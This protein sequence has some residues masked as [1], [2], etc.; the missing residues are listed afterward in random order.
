MGTNKNNE[1]RLVKKNYLKIQTLQQ[2][3]LNNNDSA[4][5]Q[6]E[7]TPMAAPEQIATSNIVVEIVKKSKKTEKEYFRALC[8][9][10]REAFD[11]HEDSGMIIKTFMKSNVNK[12]IVARKK[13]SRAIVGYAAIL[14]EDASKEYVAKQRKIQ[15]KHNIQVPKGCYLMRIGVRARCQGQG[16]GRKLMA[17]LFETFPAHLKLDVSSDN[18]KAIGFYHRIG[19]EI[20][21]TY[22]TE[23]EQVEFVKFATPEDFVYTALPPRTQPQITHDITNNNEIAV[24]D[25]VENRNVEECRGRDLILNNRA[26]SADQAATLL[27]IKQESSLTAGASSEQT[28]SSPKK[29]AVSKATSAANSDEET[30]TS[31]KSAKQEESA[32][33]A[34]PADFF[35]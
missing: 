35:L 11:K 23:E 25:Q 32:T 21:Q 14:V 33:Q 17:F 18:E 30:S 6:Q 10:D 15:K 22:I 3:M 29:L 8:Q 27:Q 13:D 31:E 20:E 26:A 34:Q 12:I 16:I 19:L 24:P 2:A 28:R 9:I 1:N 7:A 5:A 4:A